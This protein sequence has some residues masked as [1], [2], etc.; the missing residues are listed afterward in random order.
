VLALANGPSGGGAFEPLQSFMTNPAGSAI[1]N[2]VGAIR[3]VVQGADQLPRRYLVIV[4]GTEVIMELRPSRCK[5]S[6]R[7]SLHSRKLARVRGFM[8]GA[9]LALAL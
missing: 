2:A 1:V 8:V 6:E 4:S 7:V 5:G 9:T 3:Q